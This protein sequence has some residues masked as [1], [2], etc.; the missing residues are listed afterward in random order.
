M[1][2]RAYPAFR[3]RIVPAR[4][5]RCIDLSPRRHSRFLDFLDVFGSLGQTIGGGSVSQTLLKDKTISSC[6]A[7]DP[8]S[9]PPFETNVELRAGFGGFG[10]IYMFGKVNPGGCSSFGAPLGH[11]GAQ[12]FLLPDQRFTNP[13][14]IN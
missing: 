14:N 8:P 6:D 11:L 9:N 5:G 4:F 2:G 13:Q 3:S 12:P 1:D 10:T 7:G